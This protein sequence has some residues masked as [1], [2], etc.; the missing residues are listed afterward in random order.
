[1]AQ[2]LSIPSLRPRLVLC[3]LLSLLGA[4][5]LLASVACDS[6]SP[7]GTSPT[8]PSPSSA[9]SPQGESPT[10][11]ALGDDFG[12]LAVIE[13]PGGSLA[14][15]GIGPVHIEE[16]CVRMTLESGDALFLIWYEAQVTWDES[17]REITFTS[18]AEPD[19]E[20][21]TIKDGD[22]I[23]VGGESLIGDEPVERHLDWLAT[24]HA[25]CDGEAWMVSGLTKP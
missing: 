17:T 5:T 13:N 6:S 21:I 23:T 11:S 22:T 19:A 14:R 24:P 7:T 1:M 10:Q 2:M 18:L 12:P 16:N 25:S 3:G 9:Q 15:G 8:D 4:L 20:P